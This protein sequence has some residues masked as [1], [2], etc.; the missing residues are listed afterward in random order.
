MI[1][2]EQLI[3]TLQ[4]N[5]LQQQ[6]HYISL[7]VPKILFNQAQLD[8]LSQLQIRRLENQFSNLFKQL[9]TQK[10]AKLN[11][12]LFH[13]QMA[14]MKAHHILDRLSQLQIRRLESQYRNLFIQLQT[15][16]Q[17]KLNKLLFH[18]LMVHNKVLTFISKK[19]IE[20]MLISLEWVASSP[21]KFTLKEL[22]L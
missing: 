4:I 5:Y 1:C 2:F 6:H 20:L 7:V 8:R 19:G 21:L 12:L 11:K 18:Y 13:Y 9:Q 14:H 22:Q 3:L 10:Q 15:Q 17:A 16:K